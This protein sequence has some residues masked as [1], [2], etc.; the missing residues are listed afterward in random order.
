MQSSM[1]TLRPGFGFN[2]FLSWTCRGSSGEVSTASDA[3]RT[4]FDVVGVVGDSGLGSGSSSDLM[5][6]PSSCS[7]AARF[8]PRHAARFFSKSSNAPGRRSTRCSSIR[9]PCGVRVRSSAF[10]ESPISWK[11]MAASVVGYQQCSSI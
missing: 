2:L 7:S 1:L 4:G 11:P 6:R 5:K 10:K 9:T 3:S 8:L